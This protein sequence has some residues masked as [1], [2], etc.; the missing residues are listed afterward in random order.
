M[1]MSIHILTG[2]G[3]VF[4]ILQGLDDSEG[5]L[6]ID[7]NVAEYKGLSCGPRRS[8]QRGRRYGCR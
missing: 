1:E 6:D 5:R 8:R 3:P 4:C 7:S 2:K